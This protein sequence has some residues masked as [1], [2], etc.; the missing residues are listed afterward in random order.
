MVLTLTD[1]ELG[2]RH[3]FNKCSPCPRCEP[4]L[5]TVGQSAQIYGAWTLT[6][7]NLQF[8][9]EDKTCT[10]KSFNLIQEQLVP[11]GRYKS[12]KAGRTSFAQG[13]PD[14]CRKSGPYREEGWLA[15]HF[16]SCCSTGHECD[17]E[18]KK[19]L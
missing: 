4:G 2:M 17:K 11:L 5:G 12:P 1:L 18:G 13:D 10:T 16:M 7:K 8:G 15:I 3:S 14:R 19:L 6:L 9:E